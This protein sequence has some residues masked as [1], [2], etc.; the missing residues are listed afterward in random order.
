MR[1]SCDA[2]A[3]NSLRAESRRASRCCISLKACA[4]W[5][6]SSSESIGI[7]SE[8]LPA[9]TSRAPR[10]RRFTRRASALAAKYPIAVASSSAS[11][12]AIRIWRWI[13]DD[14]LLHLVERLREDDHPGRPALVEQRPCHLGELAAALGARRGLCPARSARPRARSSSTAPRRVGAAGVGDHVG[15]RLLRRRAGDARCSSRGMPSSVTRVPVSSPMARV[16]RSSS[17][18]GHLARDRALE[19]ARV[20]RRVAFERVGLLLRQGR[21]E[22]RHDV[23][24]EDEDRAG[25]DAEEQEREPVLDRFVPDPVPHRSSAGV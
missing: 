15:R 13:N 25:R 24:V 23:E 12:P 2:F 22:L 11:S 10:S 8:K 14:V 21:L 20:R 18:G 16:I 9:A 4:S 6:S 5:P 1:S 17:R 3:M 19:R 7:G